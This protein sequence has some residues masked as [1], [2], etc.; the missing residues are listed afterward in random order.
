M[1]DNLRN[2]ASLFDD[3]PELEPAPLPSRPS[4]RAPRR[5]RRFLGMTPIQRFVLS[6]MLMTAVCAL[7][8]LVMLVSGKF[9]LG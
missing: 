7:G 9:W 8:T 1:F 5:P 4:V 6:L 2:D 3:E